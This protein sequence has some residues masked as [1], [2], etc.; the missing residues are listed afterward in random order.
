MVGERELAAR[1]ARLRAANAKL[2]EVVDR[3]A[4]ELTTARA[5]LARQ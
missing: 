1:I 2:R 3:Q 4:A 5:H